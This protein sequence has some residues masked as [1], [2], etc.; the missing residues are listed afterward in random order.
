MPRPLRFVPEKALVEITART[1]QGRLL[2]RPSPE[3]NDLVLGIIGKAQQRYGMVIHAFVVTSTH[4]H[5]ILSPTS[6]EQLARFMQFVN[7]NIAKEAGR[8]HLWPERLWSRNACPGWRKSEYWSGTHRGQPPM[9][10]NL[11]RALADG[12][13]A[14]GTSPTVERAAQRV[15]EGVHVLLA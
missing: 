4:A 14:C 8:L 10:V 2:L 5:Y 9:A 12:S 3:L 13:Q 11:A 6:A 1:L 15:H 7:A